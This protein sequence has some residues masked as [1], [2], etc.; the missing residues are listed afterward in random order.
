MW[1]I[2]RPALRASLKG[3]SRPLLED[4]SQLFYALCTSSQGF[5]TGMVLSYDGQKVHLGCDDYMCRGRS[6]SLDKCLVIFGRLE[7]WLMFAQM[8]FYQTP[9]DI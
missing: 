5:K 1:K 7:C 2:M 9:D 3:N 8:G 4:L 6:F